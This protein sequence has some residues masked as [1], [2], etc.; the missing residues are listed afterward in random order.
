[1]T[2]AR[3]EVTKKLEA[4]IFLEAPKSIVGASNH[5]RVVGDVV[6][7]VFIGPGNRTEPA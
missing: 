6:C 4:T 3:I 7:D 1:M 5:P 2:L